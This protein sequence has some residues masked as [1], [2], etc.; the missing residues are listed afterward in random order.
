MPNECQ[1][2]EPIRIIEEQWNIGDGTA[3]GE[4]TKGIFYD[5]TILHCSIVPFFLIL[6]GNLN[7][8]FNLTL[9]I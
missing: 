9:E 1:S 3:V 2:S 7:F 4:K 6:F 8:G 5:N